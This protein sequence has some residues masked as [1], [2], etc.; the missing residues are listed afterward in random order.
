MI[1][2]APSFDADPDGRMV[3]RGRWTLSHAGE[4]GEAL[5]EAPEDAHEVDATHIERIDSVGV[6]QNLFPA[7]TALY[8]LHLD[9]RHRGWRGDRAPD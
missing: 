6:L 9:I 3:L 4:I 7:F 8:S 5:R 1:D 2:T